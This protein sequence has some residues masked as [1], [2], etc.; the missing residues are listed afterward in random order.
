MFVEPQPGSGLD[1][2][3]PAY[4]VRR[5]LD[6]LF[7]RDDKDETGPQVQQRSSATPATEPADR[8]P[9]EAA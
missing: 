1:K 6:R 9:D 8:G 2:I 5:L 3:A 4:L 7:G